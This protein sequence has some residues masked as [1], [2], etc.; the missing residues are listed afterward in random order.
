MRQILY[1]ET[2]REDSPSHISAEVDKLPTA[3]A[4]PDEH[5]FTGLD[6]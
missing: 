6:P 2:D 4:V 1:A 5:L 3:D